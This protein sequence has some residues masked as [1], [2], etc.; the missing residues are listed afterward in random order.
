MEHVLNL[1]GTPVKL[2]PLGFCIQVTTTSLQLVRP[3]NP[4][5]PDFTSFLIHLHHFLSVIP[6]CSV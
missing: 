6:D 2:F 3:E 5:I 4:V 1:V